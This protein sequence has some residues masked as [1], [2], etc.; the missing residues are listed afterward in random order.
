MCVREAFSAINY[1]S[2]GFEFNVNESINIKGGFLNRNTHKNK[3]LSLQKCC[4]QR[5]TGT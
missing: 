5:L 2:F 1:N 3:A 4:G